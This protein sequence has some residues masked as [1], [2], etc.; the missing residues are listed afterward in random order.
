MGSVGFD[1][2]MTLA[3]TRAGIAA[4]Y[5]EL[6]LRIGVAIDSAAVVARLGPPLEIGRAHV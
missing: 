6:A 2:D 5:D 1:L 3:D 4:V